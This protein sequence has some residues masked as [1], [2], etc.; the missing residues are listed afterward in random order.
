VT[1]NASPE[2]SDAPERRRYEARI[3]GEVAGFLTYRRG[4][5]GIVLRHTQVDPAFEGRGVGSGLARTALDQAREAR[6]RVRVECPFVT[7][8]LRRHHE[9]DGIIDRAPA[10]SGS[11]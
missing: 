5:D 1:R 8:W 2:I 3:D 4:D 10:G 9:Y 11:D 7:A 6:L